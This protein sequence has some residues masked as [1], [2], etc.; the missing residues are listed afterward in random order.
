MKMAASDLRRLDVAAAGCFLFLWGGG[1]GALVEGAGGVVLGLWVVRNQGGGG[2][3]GDE[4]EAL[5]G[6]ADADGLIR[7]EHLEELY[8]LGGVGAGRVAPGVTPPLL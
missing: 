5:L 8:L 4:H 6:E 2:L 3:L 7:G 1:P